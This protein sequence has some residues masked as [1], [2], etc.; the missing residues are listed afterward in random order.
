MLLISLPFYSLLKKRWV[1][2]VLWLVS[3]LLILKAS[4]RGI[5]AI[6]GLYFCFRLG[7]L[8]LN[9]KNKK[10]IILTFFAALLIFL[11]V[12]YKSLSEDNILELI[13]VKDVIHK[14]ITFYTTMIMDENPNPQPR[15]RREEMLF[16]TLNLWKEH[17]FFGSGP[18]QLQGKS[19]SFNGAPLDLATPHHYWAELLC[20]G[21]IFFISVLFFG[22]FTILRRLWKLSSTQSKVAFEALI[23]FI[24]AA[25]ASSTLVYFFPAWL[26]LGLINKMSYEKFEN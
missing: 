26:F 3:I 10:K 24:I 5:L 23:L 12:T 14:Q 21:G 16:H 7:A 11:P 17:K 15:T 1:E 19:A 18:G 9:G 6:A 13:S 4:S 22:F 8:L 2:I 20:Y 25:P